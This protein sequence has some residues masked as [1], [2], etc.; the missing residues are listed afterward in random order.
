MGYDWDKLESFL[1]KTLQKHAVPGAAICVSDD[2]GVLYSRGFGHRDADGRKEVTPDTIFGVASMSK[3]VTCMAAALLEHEGKLSFDD[4]V[5]KYLPNFRI[6]G[7]PQEAVQVHHL[8]NHT[9]GIPPLPTLSWSFAW[10]TA[11]EP[12][13]KQIMEQYKAESKTRVENVN[14]I[15]D[16]IA[17][18]GELSVLGPPGK[19]MSYFNDGYAL[20]SSVIDKAAGETL[21]SYVDRRIFQPLG[22]ARTSFDLNTVMARGNITSLFIKDRDGILRCSDNWDNAPPYRGCGWIKS[23]ALD[24]NK[25]YM[26][27]ACRGIHEGSR[28]FPESCVERVIGRGFAETKKG[29]YCYGLSKRLFEDVAICEHSGG[30]TGVSSRG[31][32]IRDGA[33]AVTLLTNLSGIDCSPMTN[34]AFNMRL[35]LPLEQ[36]HMWAEEVWADMLEEPSIYTGV[37]KSRES[38]HEQVIIT[39]NDSGKLI[40]QGE[41]GSEPIIFCGGNV[42]I[43]SGS[44]EVLPPGLVLQFHACNGQCKMVSVGSRI[45][46]KS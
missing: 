21:E 19:Y 35:G 22:M 38:M 1:T 31:G 36:S 28:V 24:M 3:S 8:A 33:Y 4:P 17:Q 25:Y 44:G 42:F 30:L 10:N 32:F 5:T 2:T 7:T 39:T 34:A 12:W 46:Q 45:Y 16:F 14:D 43:S 37:Y 26:A 18:D 13:N 27:L 15:I 41:K 40:C 23:T 29:T 20:L 11:S 6:P 9:T